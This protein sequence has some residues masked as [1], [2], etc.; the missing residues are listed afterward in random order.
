MSRSKEAII[1]EILNKYTH[2]LADVGQCVHPV[3]RLGATKR[4]GFTRFSKMFCDSMVF[5]AP[6]NSADEKV[7][8]KSIGKYMADLRKAFGK[9]DLPY[10]SIKSLHSGALLGNEV[11]LCSDLMESYGR[12]VMPNALQLT[13]AQKTILSQNI[14]ENR[15]NP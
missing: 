7:K 14:L 4:Q 1:N 5:W 8:G 15:V 2:N 13:G 11:P 3:G 9:T 12:S 10:D 6:V